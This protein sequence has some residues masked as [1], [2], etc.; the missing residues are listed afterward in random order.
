MAFCPWGALGSGNFKSAEQRAQRKDGRS[1]Y[2]LTPAA[3]AVSEVLERIANEKATE[4]TS[5]ALAYVMQKT[6]YVFPV[7]GGRK[8]EH[9]KGNIAG[10]KVRLTEKD[11]EDIEAANPFDPG[12]PQNFLGGPR[13]VRSARDIVLAKPA[14]HVDYVTPLQVSSN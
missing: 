4:I 7:I 1:Y 13:G 14:G 5:I 10:L 6:P 11:I 8:I 9:L 3:I 12:F 2:E